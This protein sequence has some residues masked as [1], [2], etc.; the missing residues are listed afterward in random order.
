MDKAWRIQLAERLRMEILMPRI[1]EFRTKLE[2]LRNQPLKAFLE[3][4]SPRITEAR[5]EFKVL[6]EVPVGKQLATEFSQIFY[7]YTV[8]DFNSVI[9]ADYP[10]IMGIGN[11]GDVGRMC[12]LYLNRSRIAERYPDIP[13]T[14][15]P[16]ISVE[17]AE[18][19]E[20]GNFKQIDIACH[21]DDMRVVPL[22][23]Q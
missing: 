22:D 8:S 23:D 19:V 14:A 7:G 6:L 18:D 21:P 10:Y 9:P 16:I 4:L 3:F 1:A 20:T 15:I 13:L 5:I 12:F 2:E 11:I 17:T